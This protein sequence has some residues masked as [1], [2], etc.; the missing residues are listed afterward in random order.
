MSEDIKRTMDVFSGFCLLQIFTG[1]Y[2]SSIVQNFSGNKNVM[3]IIP[4]IWV[5]IS[6]LI[7]TIY[8]LKISP[9]KASVELK[10]KTTILEIGIIILFSWA[11]Y[12]II[13]ISSIQIPLIHKIIVPSDNFNP[14][15]YFE[16]SSIVIRILLFLFAAAIEE[17]MFRGVLLNKLRRYGDIFAVVVSAVFFSVIHSTTFFV[18]IFVGLLLGMVYIISNSISAVIILHAL[19]NL[20]AVFIEELGLKNNYNKIL[21]FYVIILGIC[22]I[23][24]L[25]DKGFKS[26]FIALKNKYKEEAS[27]NKGKY[28]AAFKSEIFLVL[29]LIMGLNIFLALSVAFK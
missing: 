2:V 4:F 12:R 20:G 14:F 7:P 28:S 17:L 23:I 29:A 10:Y 5:V 15:A 27:H 16:N 26:T 1:S 8:I 22:L 18:V 13:V 25:L 19:V 6:I 3:M 21:L 9:L 24:M 11:L